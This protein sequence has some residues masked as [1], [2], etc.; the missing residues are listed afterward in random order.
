M[1]HTGETRK[2][3]LFRETAMRNYMERKENSVLPSFTRG[4]FTNSLWI[5]SFLLIAT[6]L[7]FI[8]TFR[9]PDYQ[10][11]I[12]HIE[13]G[14]S[15]DDSTVVIT[16]DLGAV[17]QVMLIEHDAQAPPIRLKVTGSEAVNVQDLE[18]TAVDRA[19]FGEEVFV[20]TVHS[21][22][23]VSAEPDDEQL[24]SG[25]YPAH[26]SWETVPLWKLLYSGDDFGN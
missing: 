23:D 21:D 15:L 16:A 3:D 12:V 14:S 9:A 11:E 10:S 19:F 18:D 24:R 7:T 20:L 8:L 2:R 5:I 6:A 26:V 1:S 17:P 25:V 4:F 22:A 13:S